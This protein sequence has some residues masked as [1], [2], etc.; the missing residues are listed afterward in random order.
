MIELLFG[1]SVHVGFDGEYNSIHPHIR[2]REREYIAGA[3]YNSENNV[4]MYGGY[5]YKL[6]HNS[7]IEFGAVTGYNKS[8]SPFIRYTEDFDDYIFYVAPGL[9]FDRDGNRTGVGVVLGLE[10]KLKD[11]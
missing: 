3:Y 10:I 5:E 11:N 2:F 9:E 7:A 1:L 4:S 8:I 6:D